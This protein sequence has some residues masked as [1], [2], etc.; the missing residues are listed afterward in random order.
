MSS[1]CTRLA[2]SPTGALHLGNARTFL[3]NWA[4]ARQQGWRVVL[5]IEDLDT[6]RVK[7]CADVEAIETLRWLGMDWD[8]GP[9]YQLHDL[10]RYQAA[11]RRLADQGLLY[12]CRC[13]RSQIASAQSAPHGDEHELQ[14][15]GTCRP[16]EIAPG[17]YDP[18][19]DDV[20]WRVRV[21]DETITFDD[22]FAGRRELNVQ[23]HVGDFIVAT[24]AG[25]PAY[26]LAV[27][28]DDHD[29]GVTQIVRGDDLIPSTPRQMLLYRYLGLSP[30]PRYFHVPLVLGPDGR[31]LAKRHGDTRLTTFH[32]RGVT[33]ERVVGLV[34]SWCGIGDREPM[35]AAE[36]TRRFDLAK[37]P[38]EPVT[39][40]DADQRWLLEDVT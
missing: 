1:D 14:Y 8:Q 31:R 12:P 37:L 22:G 11:L 29:Q 34:A 19:A 36:F 5:R 18:A 2:P 21:P 9:L 16:A 28:I 20:C 27:V 33:A 6:P 35:N 40:T 24:R 4:M 23:R 26:Q 10:S 38:H 7:K 17:R 13:T 3:I 30:L 25:L 32:E 15:P 39:Y